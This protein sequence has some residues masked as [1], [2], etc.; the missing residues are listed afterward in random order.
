MLRP[1]PGP[2]R[3]PRSP[4]CPVASL[5]A[6]VPRSCVPARQRSGVTRYSAS[7]AV[8]CCASGSRTH[9]V[10][11]SSV[12][13]W[14][15]ALLGQCV[16][17]RQCRVSAVGDLAAHAGR[18]LYRAPPDRAG[19][20]QV[21]TTQRR[22]RSISGVPRRAPRL[23]LHV[24]GRQSGQRLLARRPSQ[25][26]TAHGSSIRDPRDGSLQAHPRSA[27][28]YAD[29]VAD[30]GAEQRSPH[31]ARSQPIDAFAGEAFTLLA[32]ML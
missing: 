24:L 13:L 31:P 19:G 32:L 21:E 9:S 17:A 11:S 7:A 26:P 29:W 2:E 1:T 20:G 25:P 28:S 18:I 8:A 30:L 14:H 23:P 6:D 4:P 27:R 22:R 15:L 5:E 10:R 12:S 3:S 16:S